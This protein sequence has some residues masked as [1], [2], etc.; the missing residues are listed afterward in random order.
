M[1]SILRRHYSLPDARCW[2][3]WHSYLE[4]GN[5]R[6]YH[7]FRIGKLAIIA[8]FTCQYGSLWVPTWK[9]KTVCPSSLGI[10]QNRSDDLVNRRSAYSRECWASKIRIGAIVVNSSQVEFKSLIVAK[11]M[12]WMTDW[13]PEVHTSGFKG[14][15]HDVSL[16][17]L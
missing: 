7:S 11:L 16:I 10:L 1:L 4:L 9:W 17:S 14:Y 6:L 8:F 2:A 12:L 13:I 5:I 15:L 3:F